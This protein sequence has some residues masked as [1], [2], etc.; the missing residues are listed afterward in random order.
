LSEIEEATVLLLEAGGDPTEEEDLKRLI[1]RFQ[2]NEAFLNPT[3]SR[4]AFTEASASAIN[5][6][7]QVFEG[8][9]FG[10]VVACLNTGYTAHEL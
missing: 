5:R 3:F 7:F 9:S 4:A 8:R 2:L 6:R 1:P 10:F